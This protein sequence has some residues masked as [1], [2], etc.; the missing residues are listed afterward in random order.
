MVCSKKTRGSP[1]I[2]TCIVPA[3]PVVTH[4]S[5]G[6]DGVGGVGDGLGVGV[7]LPCFSK[8][9]G[10]RA[11]SQQQLC[12]VQMLGSLKAWEL[13]STRVAFP[14]SQPLIRGGNGPG[15]GRAASQKASKSLAV[16]FDDPKM[17]RSFSPTQIPH[18]TWPLR[19]ANPHSCV[20]VELH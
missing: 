2:V 10:V 1:S 20:S 13:Q 14:A 11:A 19:F 4:R 9:L 15:S 12:V 6:P 18:S 3:A 17:C 8:Q 16:Q 7:G 5:I